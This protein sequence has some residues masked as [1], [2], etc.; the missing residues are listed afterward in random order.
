VL[1]RHWK[2]ADGKTAQTVIPSGKVNEA[3]AEMHEGPS[4]GHLGV[5]KTLD[6]VRQR[7]YWLHMKSNSERWC[8]QCDTCAASRGPRSRNQGLMHQ[9]NVGAPFERIAVDITGPFLESDRGNRYLLVAMD[10]FTKVV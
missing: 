7:Y 4:G 10:Y 9:Y 3:Q 1:E 2:S 8:Q 6:I 5:N